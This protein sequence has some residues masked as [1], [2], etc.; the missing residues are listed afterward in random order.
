MS[1]PFIIIFPVVT[2]SIVEMQL[3]SVVLPLPLGPIIPTNSPSSTFKLILSMA[4]V[5]LSLFP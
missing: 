5:T 2:V 3:S 4:F 1:F